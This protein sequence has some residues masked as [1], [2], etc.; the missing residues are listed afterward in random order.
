MV[1]PSSS[2]SNK[3]P[4]TNSIYNSLKVEAKYI[5]NSHPS[6]WEC[7]DF[8]MELIGFWATENML[9]ELVSNT[10]FMDLTTSSNS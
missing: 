9:M 2:N 6:A 1:S 8:T 5:K 3:S 7:K 10:Y 4:Y